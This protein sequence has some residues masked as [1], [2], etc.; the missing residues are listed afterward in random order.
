MQLSDLIR[1]LTGA[2][3]LH[4]DVEV[5]Y[6]H[7]DKHSLHRIRDVYMDYRHTPEGIDADVAVLCDY[8]NKK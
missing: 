5:T 7:P 1:R 3:E 4:G 8:K 2:M 6:E